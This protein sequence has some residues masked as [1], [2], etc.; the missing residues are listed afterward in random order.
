MT[1]KYNSKNEYL[2]DDP[3]YVSPQMMKSW[4]MQE[5][6]GNRQA[7][8][9]DPFQVNN[10][11]DWVADKA[12]RAGLTEGQVMTPQTSA[13]AALKWLQYKGS[14]HDSRGAATSYRGNRAALMGHN[15]QDYLRGRIPFQPHFAHST[16]Y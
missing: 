5:S 8:E 10:S 7:L 4:M 16:P 9:S 12:A 2:P 11:G 3:R 6:G 14:V 1:G 15:G 13:D